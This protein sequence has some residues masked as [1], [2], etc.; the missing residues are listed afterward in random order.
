MMT[1]HFYLLLETDDIEIA[2]FMK[3]LANGYAIYLIESMV[4][5]GICL[6][7]DIKAAL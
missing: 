6:R 7:A 4:I 5:W 2:K 3:F 1:N